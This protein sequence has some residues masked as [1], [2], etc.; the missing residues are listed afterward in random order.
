MML[1]RAA[2]HHGTL[3]AFELTPEV[4]AWL[5]EMA[6]KPHYR[7]DKEAVIDMAFFLKPPFNATPIPNTAVAAA[8]ARLQHDATGTPA[9]NA[10]PAP[11]TVV[12]NAA[13]AVST[14][15]AQLAE[16]PSRTTLP[17]RGYAPVFVGLRARGAGSGGESLSPRGGSLHDGVA[18]G[19]M[20]DAALTIGRG[21]GTYH[22]R[23][24]RGSRGRG[25]HSAIRDTPSVASGSPQ[26][27][28][29]PPLDV[30]TRMG[31]L[32]LSEEGGSERDE[33]EEDG[34]GTS[35]ASGHQ[36]VTVNVE[37]EG[38]AMAEGDLVEEE[39][40]D[41]I[42]ALK[43]EG[44]VKEG[45]DRGKNTDL[46]SGDD[47]SADGEGSD[48]EDTPDEAPAQKRQ[49]TTRRGA[50]STKAA[51]SP[52]PTTPMADTMSEDG[53]LTLD[54]AHIKGLP[55][56]DLCAQRKL[57]CVT[58]GPMRRLRRF[59]PAEK[60][61]EACKKLKKRC[62]RPDGPWDDV[63]WGD[64]EDDDEADEDDDKDGGEGDSMDVDGATEGG[65][66]SEI[67][68][69][70]D[71]SP[72]KPSRDVQL[73]STS[74]GLKRTRRRG[75]AAASG[76]RRGG[77]RASDAAVRATTPSLIEP[78]GL[79]VWS[80]SGKS[81]LFV[82]PLQTQIIDGAVRPP[83]GSERT[84][85][86][87]AEEL[88]T[89]RT[90]LHDISVAQSQAKGQVAAMQ[91]SISSVTTFDNRLTRME[92]TLKLQGESIAALKTSLATV[93]AAGARDDVVLA[94]CKAVVQG[95]G[96]TRAGF[97]TEFGALKAELTEQLT[98]LQGWVGEIDTYLGN[99]M[100]DPAEY[101]AE[102][103]TPSLSRL[104]AA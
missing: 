39:E 60:A 31:G 55:P 24:F 77:K 91:K 97:E 25:G 42:E 28:T 100:G 7:T 6:K 71:E 30:A 82:W 53:G 29:A 99:P 50:I 102:N 48:V 35:A 5:T 72:A 74:T 93:E 32:G 20:R 14:P 27:V 78:S 8:A 57:S 65:A 45:A 104:D 52:A 36:E 83:T 80:L 34:S 87:L 70:D 62:V 17:R 69:S 56:C 38:D 89:I 54:G 10:T 37:D 67:A 76:S 58:L 9:L 90:R 79:I 103:P 68:P 33:M 1:N 46:G 75:G 44:P 4:S 94:E 51:T 81:P 19:Q 43:I 40:E 61:C 11:N 86:S 84:T 88:D 85:A 41:T 98:Q 96:E 59:V 22:R 12:A 21:R 13:P 92:Q 2:N 73:S 15:E 47:S 23:A 101:D 49:R 63:I 16:G 95:F 3:K 64:D 26:P 18:R 66:H